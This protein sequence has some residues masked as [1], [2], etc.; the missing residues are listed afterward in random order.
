LAIERFP[1]IGLSLS[2]L[3]V[4]LS[5]C[6]LAVHAGSVG[7]VIPQLLVG[8]VLTGWFIA[9]YYGTSGATSGRASDGLT[10]EGV[11]WAKE[12]GVAEW[13]GVED[14]GE[15]F[16]VSPLVIRLGKGLFH[17]VALG[18]TP[19]LVTELLALR[20]TLLSELG[21]GIPEVV[22]VQED[23]LE[24]DQFCIFVRGDWVVTEE[25]YAGK[26]RYLIDDLPADFLVDID[27]TVARGEWIRQDDM[28]WVPQAESFP[29]DIEAETPATLIQGVLKEVILYYID[30]LLMQD[31]VLKMQAWLSD[32]RDQLA[33]LTD[34]SPLATGQIRQVLALLLR[35]EVPILDTE[36]ILDRLAEWST[37]V[38][39]PHQ[40]A[41]RLRLE[42]SRTLCLRFCDD[43]GQLAVL[44]L[45]RRWERLL[46]DTVRETS[47]GPRLGIDDEYLDDLA[48]A[49]QN[50]YEKV[51]T[52]GHPEMPAV[53]L[54]KEIRL[55]FY[56][57]LRP[58]I[59]PLTVIAESEVEPEFILVE[60]GTI[61]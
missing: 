57:A 47:Q 60:V 53:L 42:L 40:L 10:L 29:P 25:A 54:P 18:E 36:L 26:K 12:P 16:G 33:Y 48:D 45:G 43:D 24:D 55:A 59:N 17:E 32:K 22:L 44:R 41:E 1:L 52:D 11:P 21:Y 39:L 2:G 19:P 20:R 30:R 3:V 58:R 13:L 8:G 51:I 23:S 56:E 49:L 35:E 38:K 9:K 34:P 61:E 4:L 46:G 5:G 50:A 14:A 31:D 27:A 15:S 7:W 6:Q 37:D 28:V